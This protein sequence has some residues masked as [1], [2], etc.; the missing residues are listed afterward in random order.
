[1]GSRL[2][3]EACRQIGQ[4]DGW[5]TKTSRLHGGRA[6]GGREPGVC[7]NRGLQE[8]SHTEDAHLANSSSASSTETMVTTQVIA[9][10]VT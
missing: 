6:G 8:T 1:M 4:L 2:D 5:M 9:L 3:T 7:P 10:E